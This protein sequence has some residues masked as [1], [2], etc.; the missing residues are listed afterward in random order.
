MK[1]ET[2]MEKLPENSPG[3]MERLREYV[4]ERGIKLSVLAT[5]SGV[6]APVLYRAFGKKATQELKLD[7]YFDVCAALHLW[8]VSLKP[9]D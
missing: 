2:K 1:G 3:K 8:P 9:I 6:P 7:Q 5:R 4:E